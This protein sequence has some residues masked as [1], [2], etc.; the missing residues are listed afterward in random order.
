MDV[1]RL[2]PWKVVLPRAGGPGNT[3][4]EQGEQ[5]LRS[6]PVSSP[7]PGFCFSSCLGFLPCRLS[8]MDCGLGA[9]R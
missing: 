5:A 9:V 6:K 2:G 7:P 1:G 4:R 8:V 3:L